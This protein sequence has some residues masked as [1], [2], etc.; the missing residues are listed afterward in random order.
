MFGLRKWYPMFGIIRVMI[1]YPS[2]FARARSVA[3][4]AVARRA[5]ASWAVTV[6]SGVDWALVADP[7][8]LH[9]NAETTMRASSLCAYFVMT[10]P[11]RLQPS[12]DRSSPGPRTRGSRGSRP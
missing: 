4:F 6:L 9:A 1:V 8:T 2:A 11:P 3:Y 10:A 12:S 7:P 5:V